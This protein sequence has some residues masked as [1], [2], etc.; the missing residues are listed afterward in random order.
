MRTRLLA[1][2]FML[3]LSAA[4][5]GQGYTFPGRSFS[6]ESGSGL[7]PF[8]MGLIGVSWDVLRDLADKGQDVD[9]GKG[10]FPV[11]NLSGVWRRSMRTEFVLTACL[12]WSHHR[13]IQYEPFGIDHKGQIRY[14]L[15]KGSAIGWKDSTFIPSL[16][17]HWRHLWNPGRLVELYS[18]FGAGLTAFVP[19]PSITPIA[20][21]YRSEDAYFFV[22]VPLSPYATLFHAGFGWRF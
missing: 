12:S 3:G 13:L 6:I 15:G 1:A 5:F 22:E 2:I 10:F 19:V 18:D 8:H 11:I 4:A 20:F 7:P 17:V 21:R 9:L 16:T 14:D